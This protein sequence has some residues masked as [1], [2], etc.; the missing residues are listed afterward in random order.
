MPYSVASLCIRH[1]TDKID[2][3]LFQIDFMFVDIE[4]YRAFHGSAF[5]RAEGIERV[6]MILIAA[7]SHFDKYRQI[8]FSRDDINLSSFDLIIPL[9][10]YNSLS[11]Q[12]FCRDIF[13]SVSDASS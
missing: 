7:V 3:D 9:Q 8:S 11:F 4:H 10:Y 6:S 13:A 1:N 2:P 12:I 5:H